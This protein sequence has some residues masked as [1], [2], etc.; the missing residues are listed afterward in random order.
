[1]RGK[2]D[3]PLNF[4]Y[5]NYI[6]NMRGESSM[7]IFCKVI[8]GK[9]AGREGYIL[10]GPNEYGLVQFYSKEGAYP[11]RVNLYAKDVEVIDG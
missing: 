10:A 2:F 3:F 4:C 1:M 6:V 9:Y 8:N 7:K 5:N 11:Y